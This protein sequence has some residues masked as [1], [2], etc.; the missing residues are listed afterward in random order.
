MNTEINE[1]KI[2]KVSRRDFLKTTS[3]SMSG[4]LL[5]LQFSCTDK[6]KNLT[7]NPSAVFSPNVYININGNG[8]VFL[9]AHR[10][11]MGTGIRTSLPLVMADELEADWSRVKVVQAVGDEKYGDQNTDGS[12]SLRMFYTPLRKAGATVRLMLEQAAAK[13]WNV[14]VSECKAQNHEVVH[15][16]GKAFGFGYLA[17]KAAALPVPEESMIALKDAKDFK[18]I[19]KQSSIVDLKDIVTGKAKFGLD[20]KLPNTKIAVIKRNPEAGAGLKSFAMEA[21]MKIPGVIKVFSMDAPGFPTNFNK[22]LGGVVVVAENT[23][24]ALKGREALEVEWLPGINADY[25]SLEYGNDMLKRAKTKGKVRRSS[26]NIDQALRKAKKIVE[27]DYVVPHLAHAPME[28]PCALAHFHDNT[29]EVWAPVQDPQGT[30]KSLAAA[31]NIDITA[32]TVNVTL[33]GGAFGRKSKPDFVVEAALISKEIN[34]PVKIMWTREDDIQHGF[35]HFPSAQ[36]VKVGIDE[37][38]NVSA[39]L[40]RS[41]FPSIGGTADPAAKEPSGGELSLGMIDLPYAI[42]NISCETQQAKTK[43]RIGWLRSVSNIQHAFAVGCTLDEV[44]QARGVDPV[45]NILDMLGADRMIDASVLGPEFENYGEK[46]EDFPWNTGRLRN[47]IETVREKS[48]WGKSLP[49][50]SGQGIAVHR[51]FLTYV[52]CVVEV[53]VDENSKIKIIKVDYAVDCGVPVNPE[54]ITSQFEGGAAFAA[55]LALKSEITVV[56]S[57]VQQ[58]NFHN[59][60]VA[61]MADAPYETAVHIIDSAEKP[62]GVG[63]PP[64]PP[65][66]P[67]LCNAI[68]AA[69]GKRVRKLPINLKE[70]VNL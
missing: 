13:E 38:N 11:E 68:F 17:E 67:A 22:P 20:S 46:L 44:A 24:A 51:S 47:V 70:E 49:K 32:V 62:T 29:C 65:F 3:M 1:H 64:V 4:L 23:W 42:E 56:K 48:N 40:H 25:N 5:G 16:S 18:Y 41:V 7:G 6:E 57:A 8:D 14:D 55:S 54:R 28:T 2:F 52:A 21:A 43:I 19:T 66:I 26:G 60:Q 45:Q 61:R 69:T 35:Y 30:R 10:S 59:Y 31:L 12:Y 33:L 27:A 15:T 36:H 53:S 63:E 9:I 37:N 39:W 58:S 50:G 34:A